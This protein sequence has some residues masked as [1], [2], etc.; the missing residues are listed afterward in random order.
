MKKLIALIIGLIGIV[1]FGFVGATPMNTTNTTNTTIIQ[2]AT[3]LSTNTYDNVNP[4]VNIY[5]P[6]DTIKVG[7]EGA[8]E[9]S[10]T[11]PYSS[12]RNL[13]IEVYLMVP[14]GIVVS[15]GVNANA[16]GGGVY[17]TQFIVEPGNTKTLH[18]KV[19][20]STP[21]TYDIHGYV[22]YK[23]EGDV[24]YKELMYDHIFTVEET[25]NSIPLKN[26]NL[27]T[28]LIGGVI[29]IGIILAIKH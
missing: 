28:V 16:G 10:A 24:Y 22:R 4:I 9:I 13:I 11:N 21:G 19:E 14:S 18:L 20:G 3:T 12:G 27:T 23:Y 15:G 8:I 5:T 25:N 2:N 26:I 7:K 29:L 6:I 17:S 1:G